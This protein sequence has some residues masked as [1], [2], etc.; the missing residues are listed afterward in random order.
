MTS[1]RGAL[2]ALHLFLVWA[3]TAVMVPTIG[4]GLLAV[5]WVGGTGAA[6]L[7]FAVGA[8]FMVSL[9]AAVGK[10]ARTVVPLCGSAPQRLRWAAWVFGLGTVGV[11][12]GFAAYS[13]G[14]DLGSAGARV[15]LTGVPYA[16]AAA[17]FVPGWWVRPA[18][19]AALAAGVAY[20]GFVGPEQAQQRRHEAEVAR[21]RERSEL[22]YL[23]TAP[24]GL[25]VARVE[26][27]PAHLGVDYRPVR[28]GSGW[29]HLTVRRP[30]TPA[31]RCPEP[32]ETGVT[33]TVD[34]SGEMLRVHALPGGGHDVTLV[35]RHRGVE[36]EVTGQSLD[37]AKLR[38]LLDTL[39]PL[40]DPELELETLIREKKIDYRN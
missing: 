36:V 16:V 21:Y 20:G 24:P 27:G 6:M 8:P 30:V 40:S 39:H 12:A 11:L 28:D 7:V 25:L 22:L 13:K 37:E 4:V 23:G 29:V 33:C 35:R 14:V 18:A 26:T 17:V 10:Q 1:S 34:A 31:L 32:A 3:T 2:T 38:R 19:L 15:A 9:L 5:A